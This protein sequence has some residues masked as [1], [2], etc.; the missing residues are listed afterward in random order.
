MKRI[1]VRFCLLAF[2][3]TATISLAA[4][5]AAQIVVV[6]TGNPDIDVPAV[7][8]AVD[9]GGEII[10]KG[11]FSF[12]KPPT[13]PSEFPGYMVTILLS[14]SVAISGARDEDGPSGPSALSK[15]DPLFPAFAFQKRTR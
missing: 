5:A 11:H 10:L 3:A 6:G 12:D 4:R 9:Q 14:K 15:N 2:T 7:Q 1:C 13:Q 8:E